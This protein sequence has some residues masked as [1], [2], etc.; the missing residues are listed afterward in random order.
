MHYKVAGLNEENFSKLEPVDNFL[1]E[2]GMQ[3]EN[4]P[5]FSIKKEDIIEDQN[6][7]VIVL[8]GR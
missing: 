2:V 6:T 8:H 1:K 3:V 5:K 7:K 4:L